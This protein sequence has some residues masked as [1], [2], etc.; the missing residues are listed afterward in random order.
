[1]AELESCIGKSYDEIWKIYSA[2]HGNTPDSKRLHI[3]WK[4]IAAQVK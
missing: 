1:M 3:K 2:K 4:E